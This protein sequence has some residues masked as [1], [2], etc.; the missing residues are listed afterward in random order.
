MTHISEKRTHGLLRSKTTTS[1]EKRSS[2][3]QQRHV[4]VIGS[5]I[6]AAT[7]TGM[8]KKRRPQR[9]MRQTCWHTAPSRWL[10]RRSAQTSVEISLQSPAPASVP[11]AY[12]IMPQLQT[13][14]L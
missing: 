8:K 5:S 10:A 7:G 1:A 2:V 12:R 13:L 14:L 3:N 6:S 9:K 4:I 11:A